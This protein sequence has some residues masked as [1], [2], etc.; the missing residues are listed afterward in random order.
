MHRLLEEEGV[1]I[2]CFRPREGRGLHREWYEEYEEEREVSDPGRGAGCI[3]PCLVKSGIV[4]SFRPREGRG[5]HREL[6][7]GEWLE[8]F[9]TPRGARVAS[10]V[11]VID[12]H[13][14]AVSD[15]ARGAGC[16]I[17]LC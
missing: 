14:L 3:F 9:P 13:A 1:R 2:F 12:S 8:M 15:P 6:S 10:A 5:L 17:R 16:I 4:G 11:G 7:N